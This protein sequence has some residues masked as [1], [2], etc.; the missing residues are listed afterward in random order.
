MDGWIKYFAWGEPEYGADNQV[1]KKLASWSKGRLD[2]MIGAKLYHNDICRISIVGAGQYHQ[3]DDFDVPIYQSTPKRAIRRLQHL[4]KP[5]AEFVAGDLYSN[6]VEAFLAPADIIF[7][8]T[9]YSLFCGLH[10]HAGQ[11]LTIE[12]DIEYDTIGMYITEDKI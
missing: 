6:R 8:N 4:I 2:N 3:S 7:S 9:P 12:Y 11:W 1:A 10:D 5:A